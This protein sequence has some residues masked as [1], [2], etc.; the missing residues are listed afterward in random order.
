MT[1]WPLVM[2][3]NLA[4]PT[5]YAMATG[6]FGSS[7]GAK[8]FRAIGVPVLRGSNLSADVGKRLIDE[9]LVFID[10]ELAQQ[11]RRSLVTKGD[12][13]F[14]CWGTINQVGFIDGTARHPRYV[15]SNK[16]MKITVDTTKALPLFLYYWFS[17]P[18]GQD[19]IVAG[20]IGS[21]VP[22]FNLG[23]LRQMR[24]PLPPLDTQRAITSVLDALDNKIHTN[25]RMNETLETMARAIFKDWF[26]DFGPTRAKMEG[27]APYLA[28]QTWAL[29]PDRLDEEGKPAG[30]QS[31]TVLAQA[32]WINGA[33]YKNM[34]FV[35]P[36]LGLP[37]VKIAELKNGVTSQTKFTNTDLGDR[38]RINDGDILFS[39]SG[40]PDTSID[41]FIWTGGPA[42]L[43][44]HIFA[45]REN[46]RR[47]PPYVYVMLKWLNPTFAELA[48]NKQTTGLGH[49]T[50][51]DLGRLQA[52]VPPPPVELEFNHIVGPI[53]DRLRAALFEN[54]ALATTRDALLPKLMSGEL[55]VKDAAKIAEAAL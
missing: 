11:F 36:S 22:G 27:G 42:W 51:E 53:L 37:V 21:S 49:V 14:T 31:E 25:R 28:R 54:R 5:S 26:V 35:E 43:N 23:Q 45:I 13:V 24:V 18:E 39:W 38:Y 29:F 2:L 47:K 20:G 48:R 33:A 1:N 52:V 3:G 17:G 41:T 15:I 50:K 7:I 40:N 10:P 32:H 12:L 44:Q 55:R 30:W 19:Q 4:A 16:Q 46:G 8:T 9:G 6:P 34:H